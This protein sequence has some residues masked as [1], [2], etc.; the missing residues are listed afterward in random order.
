MSAPDCCRNVVIFL[1]KSIETVCGLLICNR[2]IDN[3]IFGN[4][5][6]GQRCRHSCRR[7]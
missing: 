7:A 4:V 5:C 3:A 6:Q 2:K 1:V